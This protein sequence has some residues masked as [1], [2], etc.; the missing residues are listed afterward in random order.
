MF[1]SEI[2]LEFYPS[3]EATMHRSAAE[4]NPVF[5]IVKVH[6]MSCDELRSMNPCG[7]NSISQSGFWR[8]L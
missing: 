2:L 3:I 6:C 1:N 5:Q 8:G 7:G 4:R